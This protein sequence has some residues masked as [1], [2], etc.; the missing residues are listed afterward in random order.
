MW[1]EGREIRK[2][3]EELLVPSLTINHPIRKMKVK[4]QRGILDVC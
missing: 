3:N 4:M 2:E 1:R